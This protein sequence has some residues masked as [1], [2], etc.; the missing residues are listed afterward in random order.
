MKFKHRIRGTID[1][2]IQTGEHKKKNLDNNN[3]NKEKKK[4]DQRRATAN[5]CNS[6]RPERIYRDNPSL[7]SRITPSGIKIGSFN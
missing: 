1:L 3:N 6:R 2:Q 7:F 5:L 4:K